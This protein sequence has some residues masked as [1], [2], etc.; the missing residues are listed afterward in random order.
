MSIEELIKTYSNENGF[1]FGTNVVMQVLRPDALYCLQ[2]E[3]GNFKIVSW[4]KTN[5]QNP[6]SSQEIREEYIRHQ[7]IYEVL[8]YLRNKEK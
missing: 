8:E 1:L 5:K 4:D 7:A 2:V 6:P 3:G